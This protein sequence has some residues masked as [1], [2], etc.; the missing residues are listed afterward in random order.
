MECGEVTVF[1]GDFRLKVRRGCDIAENNFRTEGDPVKY[2]W[3]VIVVN[4][5]SQTLP[6]EL[7][8][9]L[10]ANA[11]DM[12]DLAVEPVGPFRGTAS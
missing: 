5:E 4:G 3:E 11:G 12:A 2:R 1:V 9:W 8:D 7:G 6:I 10:S